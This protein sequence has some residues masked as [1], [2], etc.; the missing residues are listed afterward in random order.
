[1]LP[2]RQLSAPAGNVAITTFSKLQDD[3]DRFARYY[4]RAANLIMWISAPLFGFLFVASEQIIVLLLGNQWR[5]AAPV[6]RILVVSAMGQLLLESTLWLF[7]SRGQS[8]RLL[9]VLL[10]ISPIMIASFVIGLPFGIKTVAL[11]GSLAL[12]AILPW[13][14]RVA[15]RGTT[16]TLRRLGGALL[17]PVS[18]SL[19]GILFAKI[20]LWMISPKHILHQ[21]L[22]A[23]LGFAAVYGVSAFLPRVREEVRSFRN[24]W[25]TLGLPR[26]T[27]E[28]AA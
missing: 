19:A 2:V 13:I 6:F 24:L 20:A 25:G 23:A 1:M 4:L 17:C 27:V 9:R 14:L 26:K 21:L 10:I 16:L 11:A 8:N 28:P 3:A 18:L 15:F 12:L 7:V 5:E 22:I